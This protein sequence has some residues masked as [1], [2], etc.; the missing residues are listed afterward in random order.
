MAK[1]SKMPGQIGPKQQCLA[2]GRTWHECSKSKPCRSIG[3]AVTED[4]IGLGTGL[5]A[6]VGSFMAVSAAGP[7]AAALPAVAP[8]A[9]AGSVATGAGAEAAADKAMPGRTQ[10]Y[11]T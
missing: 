1:G 9:L 5:A 6:F 4:C 10:G 2:S 3:T 11:C 8:A 7:A